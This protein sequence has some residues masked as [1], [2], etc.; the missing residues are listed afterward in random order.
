M[1]QRTTPLAAALAGWLV[2]TACGSAYYGALDQFGYEKRHILKSRVE[3][4]QDDQQA[5]QEEFQ[6]T[7]ELYKQVTG[8]Q[9]G[10]LERFYRKMEAQLERSEDKAG[11]VRERIASIEQV[12][13]DLFAEWEGEIEQISSADRRRQDRIRL[14]ATRARC[15]EMLRVMKRAAAKMDPVLTAFRDEVL[16]LKHNLNASAID[17]LSGSTAEIQRDIAALIKEMQASIAETQKFLDALE[18]QA[19][20]QS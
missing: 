6:T 3:K 13:G 18:G 8:Y 9:A 1:L 16:Y 11:R 15:D 5:V 12:A 20:V 4:S 14:K 10:E 7:F 19:P 17:A 2:A